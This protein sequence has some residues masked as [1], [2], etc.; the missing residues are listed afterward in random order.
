MATLV[1]VDVSE[2]EQPSGVRKPGSRGECVLVDQ[3]TEPISA[4]DAVPVR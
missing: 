2:D 4:F 1:L 3:S